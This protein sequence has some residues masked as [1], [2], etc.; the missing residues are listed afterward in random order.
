MECEPDAN[1]AKGLGGYS[2]VFCTHG[3]GCLGHG[4]AVLEHI[5]C[6]LHVWKQGGILQTV[7]VGFLE[8]LLDSSLVLLVVRPVAHIAVLMCGNTV[9]WSALNSALAR[10]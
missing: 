3:T 1:Q 10:P 5:F 8:E 4:P 9:V 2:V 7:Y 6:F